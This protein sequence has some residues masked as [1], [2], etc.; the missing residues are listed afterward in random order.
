MDQDFRRRIKDRVIV[1]V[2]RR[3]QG[4]IAMD[5]HSKISSN[6]NK[7]QTATSKYRLYSSSIAIRGRRIRRKGIGGEIADGIQFYMLIDASQ[8]T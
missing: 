5:G 1:L 2:R 7:T 6:S 8:A 3:Y 4:R